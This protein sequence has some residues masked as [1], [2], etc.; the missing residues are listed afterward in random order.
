MKND[1]ENR[2]DIALLV[3]SFYEQVKK[4]EVIGF[5]FNDVVKINWETHLPLM[6][7]FWE[8]ALFFTGTY[9]GNPMN[10]HQHLHHIRP[11]NSKHFTQWILLFNT[12]VDKL[13]KGEK[14]NLAKQRATSIASIMAEKILQYQKDNKLV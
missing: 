1:I 7:D 8:N 14:A 5:I 13:F 4:D 3:N 12:T 9:S 2:T 10:L 11:L 6:Y